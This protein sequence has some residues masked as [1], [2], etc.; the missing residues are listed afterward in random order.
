MYSAS[1]ENSGDTKYHATTG[2]F[3]FVMDTDDH[4]V[5]PVDALMASLCACL[6]HYVRDFLNE[7]KAAYSSFTVEAKAGLAQD[8]QRLGEISALIAINGAR[9]DDRQ[10]SGLLTYVEKCKIYN[11]LS[12]NSP[13]VKNLR[14]D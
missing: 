9:L 13:I 12:A 8:G 6:G 4:G 1:I 5:Q 10:Q 7:Q 11:T 2:T 3:G 14:L